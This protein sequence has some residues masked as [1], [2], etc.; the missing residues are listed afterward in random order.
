[1]IRKADKNRLPPDARKAAFAEPNEDVLLPTGAKLVYRPGGRGAGYIVKGYSR[2]G[3][4]IRPYVAECADDDRKW[5][6]KRLNNQ[7][8]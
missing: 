3:N 2:V 1:M 7:Y 8:Q 5:D 4:D 6:Y